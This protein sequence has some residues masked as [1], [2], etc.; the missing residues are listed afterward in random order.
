MTIIYA[1]CFN[2]DS[3][4]QNKRIARRQQSHTARLCGDITNTKFHVD[5]A[6]TSLSD[7]SHLR[8]TRN[9]GK[10]D[11]F[12]KSFETNCQLT[13]LFSLL[14]L[15]KTSAKFPGNKL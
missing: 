8:K 10:V 4:T 1:F 6:E 11:V 7:Y 15:M 5:Q 13:V 3:G 12:C 14:Y 2:A 9:F